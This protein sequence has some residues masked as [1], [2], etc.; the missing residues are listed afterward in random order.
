MEYSITGKSKSQNNA[1][2][3]IKE[4]NIVFG[5]TPASAYVLANPAELLLSSFAAC[6][7]KNVE[8]FSDLMKFSYERAEISVK[9]T[10]L[11]K[12]PRMDE[13]HYELKVYSNDPKLNLE[14]LHKNI[15]KF[16]TIYN[17]LNLAFIVKGE[18]QKIGS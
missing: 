11:D 7:L 12:P 18:I 15:K 9:A 3:V 17:T 2:I 4:T 14:L 13:L 6:T 1:S 10:R 16:G 5:T 8:R